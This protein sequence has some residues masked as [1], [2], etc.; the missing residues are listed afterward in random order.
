MQDLKRKIFV[1]A[2]LLVIFIGV[3]IWQAQPF[4]QGYFT[5][6]KSFLAG[7]NP[8][9]P[10]EIDLSKDSGLDLSQVNLD[11]LTK[12]PTQEQE[13]EEQE[14]GV[15]QIIITPEKPQPEADQ[16]KAG[17]PAKL[18][19][20]QIEKEVKRI[21]KQV[22]RIDKEVKTLQALAEIQDVIKQVSE[23][24]ALIDKELKS[25]PLGSKI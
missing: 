13:E 11:E 3:F 15:G 8:F 22:Q 16:P 17:E 5:W 20:E 1:L 19:L 14:T 18:S 23:K 9:K 25:L 7:I 4:G 24:T 12:K 2:V 21:S 6:V 10:E